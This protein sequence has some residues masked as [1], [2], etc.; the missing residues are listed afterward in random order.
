[1]GGP[2]F[3]HPPNEKPGLYWQCTR[4]WCHGPDD[5]W[6]KLGGVFEGRPNPRTDGGGRPSGEP[7]G[8]AGAKL[9]DELLFARG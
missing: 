2:R 7:G 9:C 4:H 5:P 3:V 6:Y 8:G 1:M